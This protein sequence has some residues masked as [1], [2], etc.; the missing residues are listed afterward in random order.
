MPFMSAANPNLADSFRAI[1]ISQIDFVPEVLELVRK[2]FSLNTSANITL[3]FQPFEANRS[4]QPDHNSSLLLIEEGID[5][6]NI[7]N[8]FE[9][10]DLKM[11]LA[12]VMVA[13]AD[14]FAENL[15]KVT[16]KDFAESLSRLKK[17]S[18]YTYPWFESLYSKNT[19]L[20][21]SIVWGEEKRFGPIKSLP[22][23]QQPGAVRSLYRAM[24]EG[25]LNPLSV[26]SDQLLAAKVFM[27]GDSSCFS[28]WVPVGLLGNEKLISEVLGKK[29]C[30]FPLPTKDGNE[31]IPRLD[32]AMWKRKSA[33]DIEFNDLQGNVTAS[34]SFKLRSHENSLSWMNKNYLKAYDQ[35]IM[36]EFEP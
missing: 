17:E 14:F 22:F 12:W 30:V 10:L 26:E 29:V 31:I 9:K 34:Y 27:A 11:S 8:D 4:I 1:M 23:W 3:I 33:E 7:D 28:L 19:L 25:L 35:L 16:L 24:E 5:T 21:F 6:D 13:R 15:R 20:N 32:F 36:G 18:P 2:S